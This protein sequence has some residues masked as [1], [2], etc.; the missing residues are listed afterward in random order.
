MATP[1]QTDVQGLLNMG[2]DESYAT[3]NEFQLSI[4]SL[5]SALT[6]Q[7]VIDETIADTTTKNLIVSYFYKYDGVTLPD[8]TT[9]GLMATLKSDYD[10]MR[11][12]SGNEYMPQPSAPNTCSV[13]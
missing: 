2:I 1:S 13:P 5:T 6:D 10:T 11:Q 8:G 9:D 12:V 7:D 3:E 4:S